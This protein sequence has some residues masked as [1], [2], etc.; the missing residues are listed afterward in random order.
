MSTLKE[1]GTR[2]LKRVGGLHVYFI[3]SPHTY[4]M[5]ENPPRVRG[6]H[7]VFSKMILYVLY[8]RVRHIVFYRRDYRFLAVVTR[9]ILP[10]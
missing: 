1:W 10:S 3:K 4:F 6:L 2:T 8:N 9:R 7:D 5:G